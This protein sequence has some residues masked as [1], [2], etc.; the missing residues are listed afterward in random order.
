MASTR[1]SDVTATS[2]TDAGLGNGFPVYYRVQGL[3]GNAACDGAVS[4]CVTVTPQPFAGTVS[5]DASTYACSSGGDH[6]HRDRRQRR[7]SRRSATLASTTETGPETIPL[8]SI[9]RVDHLQ[10]HDHDDDRGARLRRSP[11]PSRTATRSP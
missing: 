8:P 3:S 5:V 9:A 2:F 1:V 10:E 11:S 7:R 4:N 6:R